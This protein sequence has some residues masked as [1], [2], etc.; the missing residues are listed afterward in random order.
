MKT[1]VQAVEAAKTS[2]GYPATIAG[3]LPDVPGYTVGYHGLDATYALTFTPQTFTGLR[4]FLGCAPIHVGTK[5]QADAMHL[6]VPQASS[7]F[8]APLAYTPAA[9]L[10]IVRQPPPPGQEQFR[11]Y[12]LPTS[13]PAQPFALVASDRCT[14]DL[15]PVAQELLASLSAFVKAKEA[16]QSAAAQPSGWTITS[17]DIKNGYWLGL[18]PQTPAAIPALLNCARVASG[19]A[20]EIAK[21]GYG[22]QALPALNYTPALGL[23]VERG[24]QGQQGGRSPQAP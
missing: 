8:R 14:S 22:A 9:G 1:Y 23:Y 21:T 11:V 18:Q 3:T 7:F 12:K 5:D 16:N 13:P 6:F 10:Y 2:A 20:D 24:Q 19:T 4:E 15:K 17:H